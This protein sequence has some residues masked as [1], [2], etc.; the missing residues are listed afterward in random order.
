MICYVSQHYM[1]VALLLAG[2]SCLLA[3]PLS[4]SAKAQSLSGAE[5]RARQLFQTGIE[6]ADRG[7]W[8]EASEAFEEAYALVPSGS[9][10]FNLAG[11]RARVGRLAEAVEDYRRFLEMN[12]G[13]AGIRAAAERALLNLRARLPKLELQ[14]LGMRPGD[15]LLDGEDPLTLT[16]SPMEVDPGVHILRVRRSG[17]IVVSQR[18]DLEEA[19]QHSVTLVVPDT[20]ATVGPVV[21]PQPVL[22]PPEAEEPQ[23]GGVL[24]S[25]VFWTVVGLAIVGGIVAGVL[26]T[27][28]DE[29]PFVGNLPP[30]TLGVR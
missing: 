26:L 22:P 28:E 11:A 29:Q 4:P 19:E 12:E 3:V 30:G 5:Q 9:I 21:P 27:R 20:P 16:D 25:P 7:D 2:F 8:T 23:R 14:V 1:R 13:P 15:E 17:R 10:L 6:A 18:I 24:R